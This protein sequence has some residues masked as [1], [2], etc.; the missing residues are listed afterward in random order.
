MW[1]KH[2]NNYQPDITDDT[3][4]LQGYHPIR[5]Q[6][7]AYD[8]RVIRLTVFCQQEGQFLEIYLSLRKLPEFLQPKEL[9]F[10]V[11]NNQAQEEATKLQSFVFWKWQNTLYRLVWITGTD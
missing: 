5:Y 7:K 1:A 6:T 10:T 11:N 4:Q 9:F 8:E 3:F 2:Y